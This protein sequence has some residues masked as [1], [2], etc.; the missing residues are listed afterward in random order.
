[1]D[2]NQFRF[3]ILTAQ[4]SGGSADIAKA[5]IPA[6]SV[7]HLVVEQDNLAVL[8]GVAVKKFRFGD[9]ANRRAQNAVSPT[10]FILGLEFNRL[11]LRLSQMN[12]VC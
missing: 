3:S 5:T 6:T 1:M 8:Q 9:D 12:L 10:S 2:A 11:L 4:K 7:V